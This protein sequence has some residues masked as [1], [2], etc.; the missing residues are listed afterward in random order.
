MVHDFE[1]WLSKILDFYEFTLAS[2]ALIK[3]RENA[4]F[5]VGKEDVS[6]QKRQVTPGDYKRILLPQTILTL[7]GACRDILDHLEYTLD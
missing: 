2:A 5:S 6:A 4:D 3:I 7:N 1:T